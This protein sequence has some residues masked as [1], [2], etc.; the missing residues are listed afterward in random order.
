MDPPKKVDGVVYTNGKML[1]PFPGPER[2]RRADA[3]D[4]EREEFK[5]LRVKR[6]SANPD[7]RG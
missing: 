3:R 5:M 4:S 1:P 7:R 2:R 6:V